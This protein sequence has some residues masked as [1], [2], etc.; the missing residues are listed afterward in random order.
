MSGGSRHGGRIVRT[1]VKV[2]GITR[3]EDAAAAAAS[4]AD[5]I[6]LVF[7]P[8]SPRAVGAETAAAICRVLPPFV[9]VVA[10]FL[11]AARADIE[12]VLETVPVDMLQ[13]HGREPAVDCEGYGRRYIKALAMAEG[14]PDPVSQAARHPAA[15]GFLLD[16]HALGGAGGTGTAFDWGL[17]P[18][19]IGRPL[20]L[21]G[22]LHP[23][24]VAEAIERT[25]PWAVDVSSGVESAPGI[26]DHARIEAFVREVERVRYQ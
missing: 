8:P 22:G 24:N 12:R 20:V 23:G 14:E 5:A 16:S 15:S 21:A 13:F 25:Q 6:G 3:A 11:D 17:Y 10:L 26:K 4:G 1:R 9:T 7:Y 18:G 19:D 2:C